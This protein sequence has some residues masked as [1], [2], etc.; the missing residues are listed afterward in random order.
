MIKINDVKIPNPSTY[1]IG[2]Y[3]ISKASRVA[4]GDIRI[5]RVATKRKINLSWMYL[6]EKELSDLLNLVSPVFF[7]VEYTNPETDLI[8]TGTFYCGDRTVDTLRYYKGRMV[9]GNIKLNLI[10]R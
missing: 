4:S 7:T 2:I 9:Y 6:P 10:E 5:E 8:E 3:D 1:Q